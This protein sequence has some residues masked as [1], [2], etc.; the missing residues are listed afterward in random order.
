MKDLIEYLCFAYKADAKFKS[1]KEKY[2]NDGQPDPEPEGNKFIILIKKF[3]YK[4][5]ILRKGYKP[6]KRLKKRKV[7]FKVVDKIVKK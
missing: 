5:K 3:V 2:I 7:L 6:Y 1:F 4:I